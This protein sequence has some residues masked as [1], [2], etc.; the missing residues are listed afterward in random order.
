MPL[1]P[2]LEDPCMAFVL[3]LEHPCMCLVHAL[4]QMFIPCVVA[5]GVG[6]RDRRR[7]GRHIGWH[8]WAMAVQQEEAVDAALYRFALILDLRV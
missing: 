3:A 2:A 4:E 1:V 6:I 5:G 8:H 7:G